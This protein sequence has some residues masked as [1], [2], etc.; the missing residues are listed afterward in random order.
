[1][2]LKKWKLA[3]RLKHS[4]RGSTKPV[5]P[6]TERRAL[7]GLRIRVHLLQGGMVNQRQM[8][9]NTNEILLPVPVE[10]DIRQTDKPVSVGT[11]RFQRDE[12]NEIMKAEN[13]DQYPA[14]LA[15]FRKQF[16]PN[17]ELRK[18]LAKPARSSRQ[19]MMRQ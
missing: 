19:E 17:A 11:G 3:R 4:I 2:S 8:T 18:V 7:S 5:L 13:I 10:C 9:A 15:E 16:G 6:H 12:F 1:M 14:V